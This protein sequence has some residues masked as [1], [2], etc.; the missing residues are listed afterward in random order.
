MSGGVG[1]APAEAGGAETAPLAGE[2][3]DPIAAAG[4]AVDAE[5]TV[6]EEAALE[7]AAELALDESR[8]GTVARAGQEALEFR[9]HDAV[10]NGLLGTMALV[11]GWDR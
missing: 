5:K 4:V 7:E 10:E 2:G 8:Q 11:G 3:D 6:G 1:H 9:L